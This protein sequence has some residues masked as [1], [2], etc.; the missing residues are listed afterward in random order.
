MTKV[1]LKDEQMVQIKNISDTLIEATSHFVKN[2]QGRKF[3][4]SIHIFT[5]IVEGFEAISKVITA[6]ETHFIEEEDLLKEIEANLM[7]IANHLEKKN[8][9]KITEIV[10]FSLLP[11]FRALN[12]TFSNNALIKSTITIG[13]YYDRANPQEAYPQ[14]RIDALIQ[15]ANTQR[16]NLIFFS[17]KDVDFESK[18]IRAKVFQNGRWEKLTTPFP[19]VINNIGV[20]SK[21]QQSI[22]ERRLRRL[23]PFTSFG[24]GNKFYLPKM[25]VKQR[26]FAELLVP[27]KMITDE[28]I[29][30]DYLRDEEIA[31]IKPILGARGENI[32]FVRKKG[33]RFTV[34]EHRQERIYNRDKFNEWIQTTLLR[35]KFSYMIQRYIECRTKDGEPFDIRAHTQKDREGKWTITKIYPRIG[36]KDSILTN[37]SRGGRTEELKTFLVKE[38]GESI[39]DNYNKELHM[40]S[41]ELSE[42]LDRLHNFSL[43]ELGL[44]L[45]I[46]HN[47]RFWLHEANNGPQSTYH[48][49]ERA[50]N[51]IGYAKFIAE[52]GIVKYNQFQNSKDQFNAKTSDLPFAKIDDRYRI[53]ML[54]SKDGDD[55]L[56]I[57]CAYVAHYENVQFYTFTSKDIDFNEM[58]IKGN[59]YENGQW[60]SKIVEYPD[61]IY[62]RLRLKGVQGFNDVYE[63]LDGIPFTNEFYGNSISKLEVYDKLKSTGELD[64]II[65]PYKK[66]EKIKDIFQFMDQYDAVILKPEVGSFARGVHYISRQGNNS[67]FV[68]KS[69]KETEHNEFALR[70]YL[71][72]L[73]E[74]GPFIVQ[75]YIHT[76][77]VD[78][79]P[80][81]IRVHMMKDRNNEW[82]Y[83]SIYPRIG[84]HYATISSTGTGGYIG[85]LLG[86]LERNFPNRHSDKLK[87][88]IQTTSKHIANS[89][90]DLYTKR[91]NEMALDIAL[92][93][94]AHPYLIEINVNKPGII[95]V[96]EIAKLA[97]PNAIYLAA[98]SKSD[99]Q[100]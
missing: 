72:E 92:D 27:F 87:K 88:I 86:F 97:I 21:H 19:D 68:A 83:A 71:N 74:S 55:K 49:S 39:G 60:V 43:D 23:V 67:Y 33:N 85:G 64:E 53:G 81:D 73:M 94:D 65:I 90:D 70:R 89:F 5:S 58:L 41:L 82:K 32:Y 95:D 59:F 38:Y 36:S 51:T 66:V 40:L 29:V 42:H 75:Q 16:A 77:T 28:N 99:P 54:K 44:D 12:T 15:E 91:F 61:V 63:E 78:G 20:A 17:S 22:T 24:V 76:R 34:S 57:A 84:V 69:D 26:R 96:F 1:K 35:R 11:N 50:V 80:F 31:V 30:H 18:K 47:G 4:Q 6:Q 2:I 25:M 98:K 8:F 13:I 79:Q 9:I 93:A 100:M 3:I 10:Q 62:D 56:A 52:K 37:I 45:A 48:E 46:D 7:L 14:E